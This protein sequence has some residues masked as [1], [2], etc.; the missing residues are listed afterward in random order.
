[1]CVPHT[2][3]CYY[4]DKQATGNMVGKRIERFERSHFVKTKA[5]WTY[6]GSELMDDMPG[7]E[8]AGKDSSGP[9]L[10]FGLPKIQ[11]PS[12]KF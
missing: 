4:V 8:G 10:D 12:L 1:M 9:S 3:R 2:R 6:M 7:E 11:L 5:G